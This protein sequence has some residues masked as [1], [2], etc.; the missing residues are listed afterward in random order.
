VLP[1]CEGTPS[2]GHCY[3]KRT[4]TPSKS[5]GCTCLARKPFS[6]G[7]SG[8]PALASS[9]NIGASYSPLVSL[10][11]ATDYEADVAVLGL[12]TIGTYR[13]GPAAAVF[14]TERQAFVDCVGEFLLDGPAR[15][16]RTVK[17][18]GELSLVGSVAV[19][20]STFQRVHYA[21]FPW[22]HS[23]SIERCGIF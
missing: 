16:D 14:L 23:C 5:E 3:L 18:N 10:A 11:A 22:A 17:V 1:G 9:V 2:P 13:V 19:R 8:H 12:T 21:G 20:G 15:Q 6:G 7:G 4:L